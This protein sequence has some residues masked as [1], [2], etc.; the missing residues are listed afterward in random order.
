MNYNN[1]II[2][3]GAF[4]MIPHTKIIPYGGYMRVACMEK[5]GIMGNSLGHT[6]KID[7][8]KTLDRIVSLL[9]KDGLDTS[10]QAKIGKLLNVDQ[11]TVSKWKNTQ[12]PGTETLV[13]LAIKYNV[14][15]D[16]L[17]FGIEGDAAQKESAAPNKEG[18]A[19]SVEDSEKVSSEAGEEIK[20]ADV[21]A[22]SSDSGNREVLSPYPYFPLDSIEN[23]EKAFNSF[24]V[25]HCNKYGDISPILP[26]EKIYQWLEFSSLNK[27]TS[28]FEEY[29]Q[30]EGS[31]RYIDVGNGKFW[32]DVPLLEQWD[33]VY[34]R[35]MS[36]RNT[37]ERETFGMEK[38]LCLLKWTRYYYYL[39]SIL[40][41]IVSEN[42]DLD[43]I[44]SHRIRK[45][46]TNAIGAMICNIDFDF[47]SI[48]NNLKKFSACP[49]IDD[50]LVN[51][52]PQI[53]I[54]V[55]PDFPKFIR[56]I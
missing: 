14:S 5:A 25:A 21:A 13:N 19:G 11:S 33:V 43:Y 10:T 6:L 27:K 30:S 22:A 53:P 55:L 31:K 15:L 17:V 24:Y 50:P 26:S 42:L 7:Y 56:I 16:W 52:N 9:K 35:F 20:K 44:D 41:A 18:D 2:P 3:V 23:E 29:P 48:S 34:H 4:I 38:R 45:I 36:A 40:A 49:I 54:Y 51:D 28:T 39:L 47:L 32:I 1:E 12:L 46:R 8:G 37:I